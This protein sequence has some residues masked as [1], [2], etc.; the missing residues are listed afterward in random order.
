MK[1]FW[2]LALASMGTLLA[3]GFLQWAQL[4]LA[5]FSGS[6]GILKDAVAVC[7]EVG[8]QG[9]FCHALPTRACGRQPDRPLRPF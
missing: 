2:A 5:T 7:T 3:K 4:A 9:A 8:A 1:W 6:G